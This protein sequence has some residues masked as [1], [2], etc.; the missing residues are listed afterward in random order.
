MF[1]II[2]S[3]QYKTILS[4]LWITPPFIRGCKFDQTKPRLTFEI[5]PDNAGA[6]GTIKL[7]VS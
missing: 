2:K 7:K 4:D 3:V 5:L 1:R 6:G